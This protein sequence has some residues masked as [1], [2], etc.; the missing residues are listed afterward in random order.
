MQLGG[1]LAHPSEGAQGG[2]RANTG[3]QE[4][5]NSRHAETRRL[6]LLAGCVSGGLGSDAVGVTGYVADWS[7]LRLVRCGYFFAKLRDAARPR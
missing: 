1:M 5:R 4:P 3:F 7:Q 6:L 2:A